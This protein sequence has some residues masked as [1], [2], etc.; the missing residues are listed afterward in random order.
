M[1]PVID[2]QKAE[3]AHLALGWSRG[4]SLTA[5]ILAVNLFV[6]VLL[7]AGLFF[8]D[9]YRARLIE[10]RESAA[11]IQAEL[12][13]NSLP[14]VR[15]E[16]RAAFIIAFASQH[17]SRIRLYNEDG[18]KLMDSFDLEKPTYDWR[19]PD[20]EPWR[21]VA[22]RGIDRVFDFLVVAPVLPEFVEP[23][24]DTVK[25]W[26]E[27]RRAKPGRPVSMARFAPDLTHVISAGAR[28]PQGSY[29][30]LS[31]ANERDIRLFVRA[32]RFSIGMFFFI[33][34]GIGILLSMFL[35]RTIVRPLRHLARAA[36]KVRLGRAQEV[37][38]PR[39]PSRRDE[40]GL[41]ARALSDMSIALR[42]R[43]DATEAFAADVAHE[44]KNPLASLRSALDGVEQVQ[45]LA[46][47]AQLMEVAKAD[48]HRMD[49]LISDI[50]DASRVD[51]QLAKAKF[52]RIDIGDMIEQLLQARED[53]GGDNGVTIAFARP[54]R[55]IATA[56]GE[57]V[58]LERMFTNLI[59]NAVSF[60]P[61]G[62]LV[63]ISATLADDEVII[64]V[65]DEGPGVPEQ[66][67]E[68]VFRRFHSERPTSE[69]FGKHSGLGLAIARTIV[70][71]HHGRIMVRDR[72]DGKPGACF[73][74]ALPSAD[75]STR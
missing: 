21:K 23:R 70:E 66:D 52:E 15:A 53:R 34:L 75:V 16:D 55:G 5:R 41:L 49:R 27:V 42:Q 19:S 37:T 56:L 36:V 72:V 38:V 65:S 32:E 64:R 25:S 8:L 1:V 43:I 18:T 22:A 73:E 20:K 46:L 14:L 62:G 60:S 40:I 47:R 17:Q 9:S 6:L 2:S 74:I 31:T 45:D 71:G 4:L 35:A 26:P 58:R 10:E 28:S 13:V 11:K 63:E 51:S 59:D 3:P 68:A 50:S 67:R 39:L 29:A 69:N 44:I 61:P 57:D 12:L 48:V 33:V 30:V 24:N 54:R 7:G